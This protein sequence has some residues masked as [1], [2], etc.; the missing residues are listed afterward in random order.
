MGSGQGAEIATANADEKIQRR[1]IQATP[2]VLG[3]GNIAGQ[4]DDLHKASKKMLNEKHAP[5][6][7][8]TLAKQARIDAGQEV[9]EEDDSGESLSESGDVGFI[10]RG[11]LLYGQT[12]LETPDPVRSP[13][14]SNHGRVQYSGGG[15][16]G[17]R[18]YCTVYIFL[19]F[20]DASK[21]E[22]RT[23]GAGTCE[24]IWPSPRA[25]E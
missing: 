16:P 11:N 10:S 6:I 9:E 21:P 22:V 18:T 2:H 14:L 4:S 3:P 24:G 1:R 7:D 8:K 13:K 15:P 23:S 20:S 19:D 17:K 25:R 5:V 12:W